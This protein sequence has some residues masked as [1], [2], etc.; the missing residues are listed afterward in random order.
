ML[1]GGF[2]HQRVEPVQDRT[3]ERIVDVPVP[4]SR[5]DVQEDKVDVLNLQ[6]Q[7]QNAEVVDV[8]V[9]PVMK[10]I[11]DPARSPHH[12]HIQRKNVEQIVGGPVPLIMEELVVFYEV[13]VFPG[14]EENVD[15]VSFFSS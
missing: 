8:P 1:L 11:V 15:V 2:P 4:E 12:E 3:V 14:M 13:P 9:L 10:D 6:I 7:E 5:G